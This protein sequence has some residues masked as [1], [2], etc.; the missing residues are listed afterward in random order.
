MLAFLEEK[1]EARMNQFEQIAKN[2]NN[3]ISGDSKK[4]VFKVSGDIVNGSASFEARVE[5]EEVDLGAFGNCS[6][7][8]PPGFL[9]DE[10]S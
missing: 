9:D 8:L 2:I 3:W 10:P 5:D 4:L 7:L 6:E 1:I